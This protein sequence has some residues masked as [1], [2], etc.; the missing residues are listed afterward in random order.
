MTNRCISSVLPVHHELDELL[1]IQGGLDV[2]TRNAH[3]L[4]CVTIE[5]VQIGAFLCKALCKVQLSG[6]FKNLSPK[7]SQ[8]QGT[9]LFITGF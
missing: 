8:Y 1:E 5:E 4:S 2:R 7:A 9:F 3:L 6:S